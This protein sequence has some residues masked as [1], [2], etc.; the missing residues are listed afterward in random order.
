MDGKAY[1]ADLTDEQWA[2]L[3]QHLR[4]SVGPGRPASLGLREILNAL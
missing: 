1:L 3:E 4:H 2:V